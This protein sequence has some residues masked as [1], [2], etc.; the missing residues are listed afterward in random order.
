MSE[1]SKTRNMLI[2]LANVKARIVTL[3]SDITKLQFAV[4]KISNYLET[5]STDSIIPLLI[6][7][8]NVTTILPPVKTGVCL[9][10]FEVA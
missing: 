10:P 3:R 8:Y 7:L 5:F 6:L 4:H 9:S 2:F 1:Y